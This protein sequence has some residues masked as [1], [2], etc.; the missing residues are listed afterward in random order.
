MESRPGWLEVQ[1]T[2]SVTGPRGVWGWP[3]CG[4]LL[5]KVV[6]S[7]V[8]KLQGTVNVTQ[9]LRGAG[10]GT[11][12]GGRRATGGK[13]DAVIWGEVGADGSEGDCR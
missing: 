6:G 5:R 1:G 9:L 10:L 7:Y 3:R 2:E 4:V 11:R 8:S 13:A 12:D